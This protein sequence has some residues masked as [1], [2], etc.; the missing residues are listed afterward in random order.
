MLDIGANALL[1][2]PSET[3]QKEKKKLPK[4]AWSKTIKTLIL[5]GKYDLPLA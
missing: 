3:V 2:M 4:N 5:G 1:E